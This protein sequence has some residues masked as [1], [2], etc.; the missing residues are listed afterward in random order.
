MK[1]VKKKATTF[2]DWGDQPAQRSVKEMI[3]RSLVILD[4]PEG[5]SSHQVSSWVKNIFDKK[6]A[7]SG[8]LDPNVT[9]VLPTGIGHSVR[10]L[11]LLHKVPKEY[12]AA[13]CFHEEVGRQEVKEILKEY[14]GEIYQTPPLRSGVKRERRK[15]HVYEIERLDV[16]CREYLLR[17]KCESGTYI[18][19]LCK[20]IGKSLGVGAHMMEL[21]RTEAGGFSEEQ[22]STLQDLKDAYEFYLEGGE[23]DLKEVLLPYE[24]ALKIYPQIK[25]KDTA[26]GA[27][28][29]GADLA[30]PGVLEMD[31]FSEGDKVVIISAK[32]EG[33]AFGKAAYSAEKIVE[34]EEELVVRTE[35]V[36]SPSGEYP[37]RWK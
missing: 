27:V 18:R 32:G 5:P 21:R 37:K 6:A 35:R 19:T 10:V 28:L 14:Q 25:V 30:S 22:V 36:F 33:L 16:D 26:A 15:R 11:D 20:D 1:F 9:G 3:P 23:D 4:K 31:E 24:E 13:M 7:H 12:I 34:K 2:S 17:I 8:T 29:N